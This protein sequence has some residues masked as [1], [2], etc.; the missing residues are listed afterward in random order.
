MLDNLFGEQLNKDDLLPIG[1]DDKHL[2]V[3]TSYFNPPMGL[4]N[5]LLRVKAKGY[6]PIQPHPKRYQYMVESEYHQL[7]SMNVQFQLNQF[8]LLGLSGKEVQ[9]RARLFKKQDMFD[10]TGTG[11]H[12][13]TTL[14]NALIFKI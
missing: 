4:Q 6:F 5:I 7:K 11:I 12:C 8:S 3:E 1:K 9:E 14:E 10:N 13:L 2:L